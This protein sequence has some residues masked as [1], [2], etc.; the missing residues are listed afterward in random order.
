MAS[1]DGLQRHGGVMPAEA[2]LG[3]LFVAASAATLLFVAESGL[4]RE[5]VE[6]IVRGDLVEISRADF[7][8]FLGLFSL[9]A[10]F[11]CLYRRPLML[12]VMSATARVSPSV[13]T[14]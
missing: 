6:H 11:L 9:A 4:G 13:Y 8:L 1:A 3:A 14:R 2:R 12:N 5:H 10:L 7:P